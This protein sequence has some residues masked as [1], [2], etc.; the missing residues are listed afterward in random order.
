MS[1]V[2]PL[3]TQSDSELADACATDLRDAF[4]DYNA[5]FRGIT[6]RAKR[7][8]ERREWTAARLDAIERTQGRR[9]RT[10]LAFPF[11]PVTAIV[12]QRRCRG[13]RMFDFFASQFAHFLTFF[14]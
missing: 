5:R 14:M 10:P 1:T 8:F 12:R 2:P 7:R 3:R 9:D 6:Q 13:E 4:A 11:G